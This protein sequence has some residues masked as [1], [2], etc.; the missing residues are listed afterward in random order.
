MTKQLLVCKR[1]RLKIYVQYFTAD[2]VILI[3][4]VCLYKE[5]KYIQTLWMQEETGMRKRFLEEKKILMGNN[6]LSTIHTMKN[7]PML[8][9]YFST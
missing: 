3:E 4:L 2:A 8:F 9:G 5:V 1:L 6:L 7:K